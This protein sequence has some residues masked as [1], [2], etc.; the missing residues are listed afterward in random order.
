MNFLVN[1]NKAKLKHLI[2]KLF[3]IIFK[4]KYLNIIYL[5]NQLNL[6]L[7]CIKNLNYSTKKQLN[8][9]PKIVTHSS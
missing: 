6:K 9:N 2:I 5:I 4:Q 3:K 1:I 8:K 7:N